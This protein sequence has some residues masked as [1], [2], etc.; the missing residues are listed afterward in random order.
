MPIPANLCLAECSTEWVT[1]TILSRRRGG[2]LRRGHPWK[3]LSGSCRVKDRETEGLVGKLMPSRNPALKNLIL[4]GCVKSKHSH[5][6]AAQDIYNS[7]LW[8]CRRA[9]AERSGFPGTY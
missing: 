7:R 3:F 6:S 9:Y 4:V 1:E 8:R 2:G 5:T